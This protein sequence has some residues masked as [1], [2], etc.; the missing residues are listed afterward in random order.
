VA[1]GMSVTVHPIGPHRLEIDDDLLLLRV[2]G[3][4]ILPETVALHEL[5]GAVLERVGYTLMMVNLAHAKGIDAKSRAYLGDWH[6]SHHAAG[7]A[8]L[9]GASLPIRGLGTLVLRGMQLVGKQSVP[10]CFV[11]DEGEAR[12]F[13]SLQ[14]ERCR[15]QLG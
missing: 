9:F 11:R 10:S 8:A 1:A 6:R 3:A 15:R 14:R 2:E 13:L 12:R 4:L 7:A 5:I